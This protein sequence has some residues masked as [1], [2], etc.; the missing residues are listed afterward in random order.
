[1]N[2]KSSFFHRLIYASTVMFAMIL[3]ISWNYRGIVYVTDYMRS[4]FIDF[5]DLYEYSSPGDVKVED[6]SKRNYMKKAFADLPK[7]FFHMGNTLF[8]RLDRDSSLSEVA[9]KSI[10][11]TNYYKLS[12][13]KEAIARENG[14]VGGVVGKNR[15]IVIPKS[16]RA[17]VM[18]IIMTRAREIKFIRGLYYSGSKAGS[19]SFLHGLKTLKKR[20]IDAIVFDVKDITGI[21]HTGSKVKLVNKY[22]LNRKG[23]INNLLLLLRKCREYGIYTIARIAVF[24]DHLLHKKNP[25]FRIKSKKTGKTWNA[26]SKE[27]WCDPTNREVQDYNIALASEIAR[28]GVDEI[29][30]DYIR[31]PTVG[32]LG[33]AVYKYDFGKKSKMESIAHFLKRAYAEISAQGAF[34]S[35]D[36]FGVVAWGKSVD[37]KKTGQQI[38]LLAKH[39]DVISPMLYPSHFNDSFDGFDHPGDQPFHY[40]YTGCKKIMDQVRGEVFV[41]PWLQAFKWR[42]S[43][44]NSNYIREQ[45]RASDKSGALGYLFWNASNK[46]GVVFDALRE[47]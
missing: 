42:V 28:A 20:G 16:I 18:D 25:Q 37:I 17:H 12:L 39:C 9:R 31:F 26:G 44:Y 7:N 32:N 6:Y 40:V 30:F 3:L 11:Y 1:M 35:I 14:I 19:S 5:F 33:D 22:G 43:R 36:I 27:M 8:Y 21:V 45:I 4:T 2:R 29:Q 13:F 10:K 47:P 24:R 15:V 23:S 34:L 38:D 46:Y 41:R